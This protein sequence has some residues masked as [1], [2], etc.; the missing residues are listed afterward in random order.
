MTVAGEECVS[1][2]EVKR[3]TAF[4]LGEKMMQIMFKDFEGRNK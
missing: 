4:S 2:V 1:V 3:N